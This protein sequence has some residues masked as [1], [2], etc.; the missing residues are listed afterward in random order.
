MNLSGHSR[1]VDTHLFHFMHTHSGTVT[2][3]DVINSKC[4]EVNV[5]MTLVCSGAG[6][7]KT[8]ESVMFLRVIIGNINI[9]LF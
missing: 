5:R 4:I 7:C 9:E 8:Y 3:T 6:V 1:A 2:K